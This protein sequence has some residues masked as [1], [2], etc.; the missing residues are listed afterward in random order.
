M[1]IYTIY[2]KIK[3][4]IQVN[5]KKKILKKTHKNLKDFVSTKYSDKLK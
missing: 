4:S 3:P 1:N 2:I 5:T